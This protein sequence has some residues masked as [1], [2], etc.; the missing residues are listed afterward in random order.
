[1]LCYVKSCYAMLCQVMI[2]YAALVKLYTLSEVLLSEDML[3]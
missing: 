3:G 2:G 1:M